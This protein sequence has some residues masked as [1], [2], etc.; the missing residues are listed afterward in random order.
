MRC[1]IPFLAVIAGTL[2]PTMVWAQDPPV[3]TY[4][5]DKVLV[6]TDSRLGSGIELQLTSD[7]MPEKELFARDMEV[8][9]KYLTPP[10]I[11]QLKMQNASIAPVFISLSRLS[12]GAVGTFTNV[13]F[14]L[15]GDACGSPIPF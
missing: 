14:K 13:N 15:E 7:L 9:C 11:A 3:P 8:L 6:I 5:F 12:G 1:T 10:L 4:K 2:C